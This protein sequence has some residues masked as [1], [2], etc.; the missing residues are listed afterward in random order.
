MTPP[1]PNQTETISTEIVYSNP[2]ITVLEFTLGRTVNGNI[3][4]RKSYQI[5]TAQ[6]APVPIIQSNFGF[7]N[8]QQKNDHNPFMQGITP[9]GTA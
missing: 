2:Y 9:K 8:E 6:N 5:M 1:N 4:E 3:E 7:S